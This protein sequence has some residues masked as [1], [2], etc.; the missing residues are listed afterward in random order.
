MLD[1]SDERLEKLT[2]LK[3]FKGENKMLNETNEFERNSK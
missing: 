3:V 1:E 2:K